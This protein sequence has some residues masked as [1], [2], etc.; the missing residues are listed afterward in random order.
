MKNRNYT[1]AEVALEYLRNGMRVFI[2]VH[3][4]YQGRGI[5]GFLLDQLMT[6]AR[7][8][9][10][11]GFTAEVLLENHAMLHVFN[12]AA[13]HTKSTLEDGVYNI[14][15]DLKPP[16]HPEWKKRGGGGPRKKPVTALGALRRRTPGKSG[17]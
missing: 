4:D 17:R 12:H 13:E 8:N 15:F 16:E 9:G 14:R 7:E 11:K 1:T 3:D 10:I 2:T 5:S 6:V